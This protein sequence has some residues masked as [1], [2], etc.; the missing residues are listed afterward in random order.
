MKS[1]KKIKI[2]S[3][4]SFSG[5]LT[6]ITFN[7]KFPLKI[8]RVFFI[9]GKVGKTRGNHAH[10]KCSQLFL[11][12]AGKMLLNIKTLHYSKKILL[13]LNSKFAV[14][15]P[16]K[17]WCSIKFLNKKSIIMVMTDRKYEF[18]DYLETFEDYKKYLYKK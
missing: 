16:T 9:H 3:Y 4:T 5:K 2:K 11:P 15:V 8:K 7:K 1:I 14:L 13:N 12:I 18:N 6:P 17:Y 10:K